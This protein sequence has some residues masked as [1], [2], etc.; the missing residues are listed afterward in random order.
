V[1]SQT[2]LVVLVTPYVA[3]VGAPVALPTDGY[4][5]PTDAEAIF[6]GQMEKNYGVGSDNFRGGYDG[7]VGFV[8]D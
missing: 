7:S 6:L 5:L 8:L 3:E 1:R 4:Q 2:E